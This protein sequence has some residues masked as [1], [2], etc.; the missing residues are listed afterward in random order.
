MAELLYRQSSF[1][2]SVSMSSFCSLCFCSLQSLILHL[3]S[4]VRDMGINWDEEIVFLPS[5]LIQTL[6]LASL[7][8]MPVR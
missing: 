1:D 5:L 3:P 6:I 7:P 4:V 2:Q 8:V